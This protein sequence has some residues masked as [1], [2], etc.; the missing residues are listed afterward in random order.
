MILP[1]LYI[2]D[3]LNRGRGV[4]SSEN[5]AAGRVIEIAPVIVM[6]PEEKTMLDKTLLHDYIF[7]WGNGELQCCVALGYVSIYN[8]HYQSNAEYEMDFDSNTIRIKTV[9]AIKK[10]EEIFINYNGTW[11]DPKPVWFDSGKGFK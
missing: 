2:A 3:S 7:L 10:G 11:N 1:C 8:H 4:F 6:G 9:Q 5:L